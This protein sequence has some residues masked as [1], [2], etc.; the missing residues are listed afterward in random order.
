MPAG[1]RENAHLLLEWFKGLCWLV[2]IRLKITNQ[3]EIRGKW[4]VM[5]RIEPGPACTALTKN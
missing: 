1:S 5:I 3:V 4:C 2:E